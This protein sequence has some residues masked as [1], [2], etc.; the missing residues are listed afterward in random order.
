LLDIPFERG[1]YSPNLWV[2]EE[3][4]PERMRKREREGRRERQRDGRRERR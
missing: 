1:F 3:R 4:R 2:S